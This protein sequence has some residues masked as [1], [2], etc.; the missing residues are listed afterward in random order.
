MEKVILFQGDSI[1][2]ALRSRDNEHY[3]GHGYATL[4]NGGEYR[5][6]TCI[7]SI[8]DDNGDDIYK[9]DKA[10][11]VYST[12]AAAEMIDIMK[13]VIKSGTA[14][15][16]K[17]SSASDIPA[18]GKT[19]TTNGSK[20]GWFCGVTPYYTI[21]VWVGYDTPQTL[22]NLWGA[23][24]PA[25]IWKDAMLEMTDGMDSIDFPYDE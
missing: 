6:P 7:T 20:D 23:T 4:V 8:I 19:G 25:S 17:W 18:A 15:S 9:E 11:Q 14:A 2:D 21:S 1:T 22:D 16:M 13:G 12:D 24:Y 3:A 5:T 10:V